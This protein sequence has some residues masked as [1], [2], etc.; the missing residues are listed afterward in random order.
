MTSKFD[1]L[2]DVDPTVQK[3]QVHD[4]ALLSRRFPRRIQR[5]RLAQMGN[6]QGAFARLDLSAS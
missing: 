2:A 5:K 4:A 1:P 6:S 3:T